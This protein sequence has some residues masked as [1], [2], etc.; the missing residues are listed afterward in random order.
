VSRQVGRRAVPLA[1]VLTGVHIT[2]VAARLEAVAAGVAAAVCG[3]GDGG[4]WG[5]RGG[6]RGGDGRN[7]SGVQQVVERAARLVARG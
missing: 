7:A 1:A 6:G 3:R 5:A 2:A 4:G